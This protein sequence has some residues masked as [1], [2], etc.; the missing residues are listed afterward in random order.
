MTDPKNK[1]E[2][3]SFS[4]R[5][6]RLM[7]SVDAWVDSSVYRLVTGLSIFWESIIIFFGRFRLRGF[8]RL[9]AEAMSEA[10]TF[11]L[12][13]IT[14]LLVLALPTFEMTKGN[15]QEQD[16]FAVTFLDRYGNEIGKRGVRQRKIAQL[17]D[18]PDHF[19]K[20][21]LSTEDRRF[22]EHYGVDPF[23][24]ARAIYTNLRS[25][26]V[27]EG[28]ST[29][30]QQL[31]KNV[32]LTNERTFDRK[33]KEAFLSIWL[34]F[35]LTKKEI[36]QLYID[37]A[38]MG[39][40]NY[41]IQAAAD[42]YFGKSVQQLNL[43]ESAMM[44]G[45]FKAPTKYAP[46]RNLPEARARANE[47]LTNIVQAGFMTEGQVISARKNPATAIYRGE[48]NSPDYFLDWAFL[49]VRRLAKDLPTKNIIARTTIDMGMQKAAETSIENHLVQFGRE[50][51]VTQG[52]MVVMETDGAVR[53]IVGGRDYGKSQFN[54]ATLA[55][56]QPGSTFK[57]YVYAH[58]ME[59]GLT[60]K[61][62]VVDAPITIGGWSPRNYSGGY[63]GRT[64]AAEALIY[65]IN[66][67][68]VRMSQ[69]YSTRV[70]IAKLANK[71]GISSELKTFPPM[72][73]GVNE[74]TVL[75]QATGYTVFANGGYEANRHGIS[76]LMAEDGKVLYDH[77]KQA[78]KKQR[79]L[80]EN[81]VRS[82][83]EILVQVPLRGTG[84]RASLSGVLAAGKTGTT[85]AYRDA[86]FVGYTGNYVAAVWYGNDAFTR[87][88]NLTG[89][90]LPA[91]TWA[92]FM[93]F[94]HQQT[95]PR[96]LPYIDESRYGLTK[97][98]T[99]TFD[100]GRREREGLSKAAT[101]E[102]RKLEKLFSETHITRPKRQASLM[103]TP[104]I[105]REVQ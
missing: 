64:N 79:L 7:L 1:P 66:T 77:D 37:R 47:V 21:V 57:V 11:G 60:P 53:A 70:E 52:A 9:I 78:G 38:Y 30:T 94:A 71:M 98:R 88:N 39:A 104:S 32:F 45:L 95:E 55:K 63:R 19:V 82:M 61:S 41:G 65:S 28:G 36:L 25:N 99:A 97:A 35:N 5:K 91:M 29:L 12:V 15:W 50:K 87:T 4:H 73:L 20:A 74:I 90:N 24:L 67:V 3:L 85:Q 75:D 2:K 80:S 89:G 42:Y 16:A 83:N 10:V 48:Q 40:G 33:F 62:R 13:G 26:A 6:K 23:G 51:R 101:A 68:P 8:R 27:V 59:N 14:L 84:T 49:E 22:F 96:S 58:A 44:A 103:T 100:A 81:T 86:W 69:K 56:R 18:L 17:E 72:A 92:Q 34:E 102:L 93:G 54:R 31:A 43:A 76:Q 46:H 105:T